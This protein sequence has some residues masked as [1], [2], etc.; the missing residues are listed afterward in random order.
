MTR[1]QNEQR[2]ASLVG[3]T[4][5]ET[6]RDQDLPAEYLEDDAAAATM[7]RRL[8]LSDVVGRQIES[9][10]KAVR[11]RARMTDDQVRD[12]VK[13]VV[14]RPDAAQVFRRAGLKLAGRAG[15]GLLPAVG[16]LLPSGLAFAL[17]RRATRRELKRLFGRHIGGFAQGPYALEG[18][19]HIFLEGDPTGQA[20][21]FITGFCQGIVTRRL[22]SEYQIVHAQCQARGDS[23]CR[24]TA[25]GEAR[26]RQA[27]GVRE[28]LLRPELETG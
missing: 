28:M 11:Q 8:G 20:C 17:A 16:D 21:Q 3:L 13:L 9:Y 7:P 14:R 18:R 6:L 12:L 24:W 22:G 26:H 25:T 5:L 10:R 23:A 2:V 4:L 15:R 27:D 1:S 19:G